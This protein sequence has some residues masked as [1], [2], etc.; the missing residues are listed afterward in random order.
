MIGFTIVQ[1]IWMAPP[2]FISGVAIY[3]LFRT[4]RTPMNADHHA[5]IQLM[6]RIELAKIQADEQHD[7][8]LDEIREKV[9]PG[10]LFSE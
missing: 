5:F 6:I 2:L 4:L 7:K 8:L 1:F 3:A 9:F 10:D